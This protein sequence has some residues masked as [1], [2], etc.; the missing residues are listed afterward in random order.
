MHAR[1][2]ARLPPTPPSSQGAT[3][4]LRLESR[5]TYPRA[6]GALPQLF[7]AQSL[8]R[9]E[10]GRQLAEAKHPHLISTAWSIAARQFLGPAVGSRHGQ[11]TGGNLLAAGGPGASVLAHRARG[12]DDCNMGNGRR[13]WFL[14]PSLTSRCNRSQTTTLFCRSGMFWLAIIDRTFLTR[15]P[16]PSSC[17]LLLP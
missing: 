7:L 17:L 4:Q 11:L 15:R 13:G 1:L 16:D 2:C 3:S 5:R 14:P 6:P 10:D 9:D 12:R 8:V